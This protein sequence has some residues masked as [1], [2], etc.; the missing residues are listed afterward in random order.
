MGSR[1]A[2]A[3]LAA[4]AT[5]AV[6]VAVPAVSSAGTAAE[7]RGKPSAAPTSS[8]Q[9]YSRA[10]HNDGGAN[11]DTDC[12]AY[13]STRDGSASENGKGGGAAHGKP[14]AGCAGKADNK[15]PPGQQR[16]GADH[17]A[18]YECDRN[19]GVGKTNPA[20][21]GC[22]EPQGA[23]T[24]APCVPS[25]AD[26]CLPPAVCPPGG[27]ACAPGSTATPSP[28]ATTT[29]STA[30]T[31]TPST[32]ATVTPSG[33]AETPIVSISP[34][35]RGV[36]IVRKRVT[37]P[38]VAGGRLPTTGANVSVALLLLLG[39]GLVAGGVAVTVATPARHH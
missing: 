22:G 39:F 25:E 18:G 3:A 4:F 23:P 7:T 8:P 30:A 1:L 31:A 33:P 37:P 17:N 5:A 13:C 10:D 20:H 35:V 21:T 38:T 14:C 32:G 11:N 29:P 27:V 34:S 6:V 16:D 9:P 2:R 28:S 36:K 12:G 24:S 26:P 15:Y 19:S